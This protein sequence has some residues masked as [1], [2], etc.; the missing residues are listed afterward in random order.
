[1]RLVDLRKEPDFSPAGL[2]GLM[3]GSPIFVGKSEKKLLNWTHAHLADLEKMKKALFTVS[4]NAAD[5]RAAARA[6]DRQL[7]HDFLDAS[8][9]KAD[10]TASIAGALSYTKYWWPIR[11]LMRRISRAAG[12]P[13]DTTRDHVLTDWKVVDAFADV[14]FLDD[15]HSTFATSAEPQT[16]GAL[17]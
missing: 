12:G 15:R 8:G 1:M 6:A 7:L 4:L 10:F 14:F 9:L 17:I 11:F 5:D 3:V 2:D 13:L 16:L